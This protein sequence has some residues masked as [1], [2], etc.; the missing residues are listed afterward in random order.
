MGYGSALARILTGFRKTV[1]VS[2]H[3][4]PSLVRG[5]VFVITPW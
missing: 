4:Y 3:S 5:D 2:P 1:L